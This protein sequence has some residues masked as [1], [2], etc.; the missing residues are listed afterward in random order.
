MTKTKQI[1]I[2]QEYLIH[3]QS[4][5]R[6]RKKRPSKDNLIL[7]PNDV[8]QK[9][10]DRIKRHRQHQKS[11]NAKA[12]QIGGFKNDFQSS[13]TY[14]NDIIRKKETKKRRKKERKDKQ[15]ENNIHTKTEKIST[16]E[17]TSESKAM[18]HN[19]TTKIRQNDDPP[20]GILKGG[21]KPLYS[22]YKK[23]LRASNKHLS[24]NSKLRFTKP[25]VQQTPEIVERKNKLS[26]FQKEIKS[27]A[28]KVKKKRYTLG[29]R[30]GSIGILIKSKETTRK[31]KKE[32]NNLKKKKMKEIRL[33]LKKHGLLRVG[34]NAPDNIL[35]SIYETS[36]LSGDVY[37]SNTNVLLHNFI[38]N[39]K[40]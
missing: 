10:L 40:K 28:K 36:V 31:I 20:Y 13:L 14:L 26:A 15:K 23:T 25:V 8:K 17:K 1:Q 19:V 30:N 6:G 16:R 9:L 39:D 37:N 18:S 33:Y 11:I 5:G 21:K 35:R 27:A 12:E 29:K 34:S 24:N 32:H 2:K 3:N 7:Q 4:K 38:N 22:Q